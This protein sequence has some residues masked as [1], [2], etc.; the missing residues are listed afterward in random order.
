MADGDER[1]VLALI[2]GKRVSGRLQ[3]NKLIQ[4]VMRSFIELANTS[5]FTNQQ[6]CIIF[7]FVFQTHNGGASRWFNEDNEENGAPLHL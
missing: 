3:E 5:N 2:T 6:N 1:V 7:L 4:R